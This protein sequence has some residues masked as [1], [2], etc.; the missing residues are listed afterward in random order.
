MASGF[1]FNPL[2]ELALPSPLRKIF[3]LFH[4][5]IVHA[6][7]L[8]S[9]IDTREFSKIRFLKRRFFRG[10]PLKRAT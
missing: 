5:G 4:A 6:Q 9:E 8:P 3:P 2:H 10:L 7:L 1:Y